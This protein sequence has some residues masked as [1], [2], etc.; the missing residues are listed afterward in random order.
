MQIKKVEETGGNLFDAPACFKP[1]S[2]S[3]IYFQAI[4]NSRSK[5]QRALKLTNKLPLIP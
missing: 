1:I 4:I 3:T 5:I 2:V